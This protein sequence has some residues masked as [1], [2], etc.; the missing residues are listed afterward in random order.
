MNKDINN[1][2]KTVE[3]ISED[4]TLKRMKDLYGEEN[5]D[6]LNVQH[7]T[8]P[9]FKKDISIMW[10]IIYILAFIIGLLS[11]LIINTANAKS[12]TTTATVPHYITFNN[13]ERFESNNE[14]IF[15]RY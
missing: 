7:F 4:K 14:V 5:V 12:V 6:E 15:Y 10:I 9:I 11:G 3:G 8:T 2:V 1:L 13:S